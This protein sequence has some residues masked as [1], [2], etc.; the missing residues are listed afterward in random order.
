MRSPEQLKGWARNVAAEKHLRAQEILQMFMFERLLEL[1][2]EGVR[3]PDL[4]RMGLWKDR[5]DKYIAGIKLMSEWKEKNAKD[6]G[7]VDFSS[8]WKVYP[9]DLTEN[10]IRR[11]FPAPKRE[12]DL[13]PALADC[14]SFAK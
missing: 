1:N 5:L 2:N 12:L 10:D 3:R 8:D 11:Y 9:Q 4:I 14:R 13:N 6:P 7:A